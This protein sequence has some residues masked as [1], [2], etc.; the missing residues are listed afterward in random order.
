MCVCVCVCVCECA[1]FFKKN[2]LEFFVIFFSKKIFYLL[3]KMF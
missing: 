1:C 3:I 2:F